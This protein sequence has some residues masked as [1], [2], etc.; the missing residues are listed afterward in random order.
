MSSKEWKPLSKWSGRAAIAFLSRLSYSIG[1]SS[2]AALLSK[3]SEN[4]SK[5]KKSSS[6]YFCKTIT[7]ANSRLNNQPVLKLLERNVK[8]FL[9]ISEERSLINFSKSVKRNLNK[10]DRNLSAKL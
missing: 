1:G 5:N 8:I 2:K 4:L 3:K 6:N 10:I 9:L 7:K